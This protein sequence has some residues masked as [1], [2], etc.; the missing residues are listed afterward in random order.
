MF[1]YKFWL[2]TLYNLHQQSTNLGYA[3][4]IWVYTVLNREKITDMYGKI[5]RNSFQANDII[6]L[7]GHLSPSLKKNCYYSV[8]LYWWNK[9][10]PWTCTLC[11]RYCLSH[12]CGLLCFVWNP[13]LNS[14]LK[15]N[16]SFLCWR[17]NKPFV[18][19][20]WRHTNQPLT[21]CSRS[22]LSGTYFVVFC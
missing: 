5:T 11:K 9:I 16:R 15:P 3:T 20:C 14:C 8:I 2:F 22:I 21:I 17:L 7:M 4:V 13:F 10:I 12:C 19:R 18:Y 1:L 6:W